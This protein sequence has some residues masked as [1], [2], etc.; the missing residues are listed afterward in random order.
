[1]DPGLLEEEPTEESS[2]ESVVHLEDV[3][4]RDSI[5][6]IDLGRGPMTVELS[7][8]SGQ[9]DGSRE[10]RL[11]DELTVNGDVTGDGVD[12]LIVVLTVEGTG[13]QG[14]EMP[15]VAVLGDD[16]EVGAHALPPPV[17]AVPSHE[18][19]WEPPVDGIVDAIGTAG[20]GLEVG[21]IAPPQD[22]SALQFTDDRVDPFADNHQ[23]ELRLEF[24]GSSWQPSADGPVTRAA[25]DYA[26]SVGED[27]DE[28]ICSGRA[29]VRGRNPTC[30]GSP[31][32]D[33]SDLVSVQKL[34][35]DE[36]GGFRAVA[37]RPGPVASAHEVRSALGPGEHFCRDIAERA[38]EHPDEWELPMAAV[39]YWFDDGMPQRM[40]ASQNGVPCQTV[41]DDVAAFLNGSDGKVNDRYDRMLSR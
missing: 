41:F 7:D 19:A 17:L 5:Y 27:V 13:D 4:T 26:S 12:E 35:V 18:A 21:I 9:L 33:P 29:N 3:D 25:R 14:T 32:E 40:D 37:G 34:I 36:H 28:L 6:E 10:V 11:V 1:M 23:P 8:G 20:G 22:E 31:V 30:V 38:E 39:A 24:D 2:P 15:A 16:P